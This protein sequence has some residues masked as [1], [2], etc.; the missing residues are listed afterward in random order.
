[1]RLDPAADRLVWEQAAQA[2]MP[3]R[4]QILRYLVA[5]VRDHHV[6]E[7]LT[8]ETLL[9]GILHS[10]KLREPQA[11]A[12][13]L[14]RIAWHVALDWHRRRLR[15]REPDDVALDETRVDLGTLVREASRL[16]VDE[17]ALQRVTWSEGL[18]HALARLHAGD[19][20]LLIGHHYIGLSCRELA[21]RTGLTRE[22]VKQRLSRARRRLRMLV[23]QRA[24]Q[25]CDERERDAGAGG[26]TGARRRA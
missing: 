9:R 11:A 21:E 17:E 12:G 4:P 8:Q 2:F 6:A 22:G 10:R 16:E 25:E 20:A 1:M 14:M 15:R 19:R 26:P 18:R 13:W 7:D 3:L 24:D 5:R 23:V